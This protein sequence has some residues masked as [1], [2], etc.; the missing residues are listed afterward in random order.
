MERIRRM[1]DLNA[2][3]MAIAQTLKSDPMLADLVEAEPGLRLPGCWDG[4]ELAVRAILGQQVTVKAATTFAG[5]MVRA[6][7]RKFSAGTALTHLFPTP[8]ALAS[9]DLTQIGLTRA[10]ATTIQNLARAVS[11]REI[12]FEG[13]VDTESLLAQLREIPGIGEWTAQYVAMRALGEPDAFPVG[14]IALLRKLDLRDSQQLEKRAEA[15]RPWRAYAAVYIWSK[16]GESGVETDK[17]MSPGA[18]A[19]EVSLVGRPPSRSRANSV[20]RDLQFAD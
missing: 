16:S 10:R 14:D 5:R 12:C 20:P 7:G 1:F 11:R 2:D 3:W 15:W 19:P 13:V 17:K 8:E 6:F 9:A 18:K 4:F